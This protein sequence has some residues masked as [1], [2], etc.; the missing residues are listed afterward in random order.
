VMALRRLAEA[1]VRAETLHFHLRTNVE[2]AAVYERALR[3]VLETCCVA[4]FQP[5]HLDVGGGLPPPWVLDRSGKPLA[6]EMELTA[7]GRVLR[8]GVKR[9]PGLREL[10]LENGRFL[11]ARSGVLV[12]RVLDI[13]DRLGARQVICDGG[14]TL[15]ALPSMWERHALLTLPRR[16]KWRR[17][18]VVHGPTCMA[19]DQLGRELL[20]VD[21]QVG[22]RLIWMDAGAY[23]LQWE[24]RFSHGRSAVWWHE[25]GRLRLVRPHDSFRAWWPRVR[26]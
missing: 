14:R 5:V 18:S 23:H 10:W 22:D 19:F 24:T 20:P 3:E 25:G 11:T 16:G 8:N 7:L 21:L 12:V 2:S 15:N 13:K 6:G 26:E 17:E 4:H 1:G 9:L